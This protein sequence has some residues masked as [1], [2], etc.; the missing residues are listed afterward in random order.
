MCIEV[1]AEQRGISFVASPG[2]LVGG[3]G[4]FPAR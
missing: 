4:F 1:R 3:A 2:Q